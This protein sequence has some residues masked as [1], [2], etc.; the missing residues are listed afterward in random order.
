[1]DTILG[2]QING[3]DIYNS[4]AATSTTYQSTINSPA[5]TNFNYSVTKEY[6]L[7]VNDV[8][9]HMT[10]VLVGGGGGGCSGQGDGGPSPATTQGASGSG[11][12]SGAVAYMERIPL[13]T[14]GRSY[15]ISVGGGGRGRG[16]EYKG[17][18]YPSNYTDRNATTAGG[19]TNIFS[20]NVTNYIIT[21]GGGGNSNAFRTSANGGTVNKGNSVPPLSY[22][23][24]G[25]GS[26]VNSARSGPGTAGGTCAGFP[27]V[28]NIPVSI[29]DVTAGATGLNGGAFGNNNISGSPGGNSTKV[30]GGSPGG[31]LSFTYGAGSYGGGG[32]GGGGGNGGNQGGAGAP[33]N[34]GICIIYLYV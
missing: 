24:P 29:A 28:L 21:A 33:G 25:N 20:N 6:Q 2:F 34:P 11:G 12:G 18:F 8:F 1:M 32:G 31:A 26:N 3:V 19:D 15:T 14:N 4:A 17:V 23:A 10:V 9:N 5:T 30:D 16:R 27:K 22:S 13:A 7:S